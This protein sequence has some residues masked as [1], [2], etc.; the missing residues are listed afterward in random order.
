MFLLLIKLM[1]LDVVNF[2]ILFFIYW[3]INNFSIEY[4]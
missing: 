3:E 2:N 1:V 4:L